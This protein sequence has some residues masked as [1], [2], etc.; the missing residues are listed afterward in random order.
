MAEESTKHEANSPMQER[1]S[2]L[3]NRHRLSPTQRRLARYI[4]D[5]PHEAPFLSSV[6]LS[7]RVGVSQPSV[8][9]LSSALGYARYG[10]LQKDLR[11]LVLS[12]AETGDSD[13]GNKFQ[14]AVAAEIRNLKALEESLADPT[15]VSEMGRNLAASEPLCVM[16]LRVS[17]PLT[18]YFGYFAKKIHPDVRLITKGGSTVADQ[19]SHARQSGGEWVLCFLL[20]R[21]PRETIEAMEYAKSLGLRVATVTDRAPK[22][23]S[24]VSDIVLSADVGTRLVFDSQAAAMVLAGILLEAISDASPA[25]TQSRLEDFEERAA[26]LGWFAA[27]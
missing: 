16:G 23:V 12:G 27:E 1:L 2:I 25:R 7:G 11:E 5:N 19:L 10:D 8:I 26:D 24:E 15:V 17:A 21:H 20:P 4:I 3:F 6:E 13:G 14:S 22:A 9:R 18:E